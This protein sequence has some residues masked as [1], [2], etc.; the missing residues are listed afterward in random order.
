MVGHHRLLN[1]N[2]QCV[3]VISCNVFNEG[4]LTLTSSRTFAS[5][6]P[7]TA[8]NVIAAEFGVSLEV[9]YLVTTLFLVGYVFG[10]LLWGPGSELVGRRPIF[11]V[12]MVVYTLFHLGQSLAPNMQTLLV[13]RF[14]AG[15]FAV[16]PLTNSGGT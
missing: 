14:I 15:V 6:A 5:S 3:R 8:S 2:C 4:R 10:P 16:A 13:T 7:S 9:S 12:S 11:V 1:H